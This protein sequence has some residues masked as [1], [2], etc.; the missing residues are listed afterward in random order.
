MFARGIA[1][2]MLGGGA[3]EL[4]AIAGMD[5]RLA[6]LAV[7]TWAAL[8]LVLGCLGFCHLY[9]TSAR[10]T[11]ILF[12]LT[13]LTIGYYIVVSAGGGDAD[14]RFRVPIMPMWTIV[15][16]VGALTVARHKRAQ[17]VLTDRRQRGDADVT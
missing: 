16:A 7:G 10:P 8:Y 17:P 13:L 1:G 9:R 12:A 3:Y 2:M 5:G 15:V 4:T 11:R 6:I 14:S